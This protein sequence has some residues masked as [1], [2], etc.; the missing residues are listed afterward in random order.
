MSV[1]GIVEA[2]DKQV[3]VWGFDNIS[4]EESK[5]GLNGFA[6]PRLQILHEGCEIRR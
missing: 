1:R 5:L 4:V 3:E 6:D 2:Y